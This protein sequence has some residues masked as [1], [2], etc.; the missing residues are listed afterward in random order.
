MSSRPYSRTR[1]EPSLLIEALQYT[2]ISEQNPCP[3]HARFLPVSKL[4]TVRPSWCWTTVRPL[5]TAFSR[6]RLRTPPIS[7]SSPSNTTFART[8]LSS[9]RS[10]ALTPRALRSSKRWSRGA[11]HRST[12]GTLEASPNSPAAMLAWPSPSQMPWKTTRIFPNFQTP[13]SSTDCSIREERR[14]KVSLRLLRPWPSFTHS[15]SL[16]TKRAYPDRPRCRRR[17]GGTSGAAFGGAVPGKGNRPPAGRRY[18]SRR[19]AGR[20]HVLPPGAQS[21]DV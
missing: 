13:S 12:G 4:T 5:R 18:A 17:D 7:A 3:T 15:L 11:T 20:R 19:A 9:R 1:S 2:P 21:H 14:T 10:Y 8:S 6:A 16:P